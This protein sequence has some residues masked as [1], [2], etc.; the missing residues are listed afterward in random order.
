MRPSAH[1]HSGGWGGFQSRRFAIAETRD[2]RN[3]ALVLLRGWIGERG[4]GVS[5]QLAGICCWQAGI[6]CWQ[7]GSLPHFFSLDAVLAVFL[8]VLKAG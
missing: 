5:S 3:N 4:G 8:T 6:R 1:Y 2:L 7:A